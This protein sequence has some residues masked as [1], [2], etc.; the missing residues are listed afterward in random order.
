MAATEWAG[1]ERPSGLRDSQENP[2][3]SQDAMIGTRQAL[4]A[5]PL[6][7]TVRRAQKYMV[8]MH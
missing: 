6:H 4:I 3:L 7:A 2:T 8:L 1:A 5:P